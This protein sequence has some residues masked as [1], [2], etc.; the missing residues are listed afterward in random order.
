[1]RKIL[2]LGA[3]LCGMLS[4]SAQEDS[5]QV[6]RYNLLKVNLSSIVF[7]NYSFQ[8]E[9]VLGKR[10][11]IALGY[12]FRPTGKLP[13]K[14][15]IKG[16]AEEEDVATNFL[17]DN[18]EIGG[19]AFTPE[20][21]W[22]LGKGYGK[23][24]YIAPYARFSKFKAREVKVLY[25]NPV[26]GEDEV[27]TMNGDIS[28]NGFGLMFGAQWTIGKHFLIDW[29]IVGAHIGKSS[30]D[31]TGTKTGAPLTPEEQE[32]IRDVLEDFELPL[33]D[34]EVTVTADRARVKMDGSWGGVRAF[35]IG[36]GYRF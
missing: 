11:S 8:Y 13:F 33:I 2:L 27:L 35:G 23:G 28:G 25:E 29:W 19:S 24:F 34:T 1:M 3:F 36:V 12:S 10:W 32:E 22:Y 26:S 21:R 9:R 15:T 4:M 20:I 6:R 16:F 31:I 5:T 14:S 7:N 18:A 17:I 30:G